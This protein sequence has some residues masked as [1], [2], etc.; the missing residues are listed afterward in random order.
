MCCHT[1]W[2]TL[3]TVSQKAIGVERA[4]QRRKVDWAKHA[5]KLSIISKQGFS[6]ACCLSLSYLFGLR[7]ASDVEF[8]VT[9]CRFF[10]FC[11]TWLS[12]VR[13]TALVS[14]AVSKKPGPYFASWNFVGMASASWIV[15]DCSL[16]WLALTWPCSVPFATIQFRWR[17][18][19]YDCLTMLEWF[20]CK[21]DRWRDE[22]AGFCKYGATGK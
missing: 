12:S 1:F 13:S 21:D 8:F 9:F 2:S 6:R 11:S 15:R 10:R 3:H 22:Y 5:C 17:H 18:R 14:K 7:L 20:S 16:G 4:G 19:V